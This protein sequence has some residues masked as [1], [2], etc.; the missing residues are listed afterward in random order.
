LSRRDKMIVAWQFI[1]RSLSNNWIRLRR[2]GCDSPRRDRSPP[3]INATVYLQ[4]DHTV[5]YGTGPV[6]GASLEMNCQATVIQSLGTKTHSPLR[7]LAHSPLSPTCPNS[8]IAIRRPPR[9]SRRLHVPGLPGKEPPK[10]CRTK[11]P[12]YFPG[13]FASHLLDSRVTNSIPTAE[14]AHPNRTFT[15]SRNQVVGQ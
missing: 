5:P 9:Y 4:T 8:F 12:K 2:G 7:R 3:T 15:S 1:A 13:Q 10:R 6:L 14:H 11:L